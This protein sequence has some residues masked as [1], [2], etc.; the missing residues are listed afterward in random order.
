MIERLA[1]HEIDRMLSDNELACP[2]CGGREFSTLQRGDAI[3]IARRG[4]WGGL[5]MP[6]ETSTVEVTCE[7]CGAV[8]WTAKGVGEA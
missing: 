8:L 5:E 2:Q 7:S 3:Q 4:E 6:A 1:I